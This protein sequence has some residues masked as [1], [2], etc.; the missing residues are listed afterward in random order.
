MN[1]ESQVTNLNLMWHTKTVSEFNKLNYDMILYP[2]NIIGTETYIVVGEDKRHIEGYVLSKLHKDDNANTV[3]FLR[4]EDVK[5]LPVAIKN[6]RK[7][8][9]KG[10][11]YNLLTEG[12]SIK[13]NPEQKMV[14]RELIDKSGIP[15]HTN[16]LHWTLYKNK[17]LYSRLK[18]QVY[19]RL[20][21]ESAFGKDK[22]HEAVR[23]LLN[24]M[25]NIKDP[26]TPKLFYAICHNKDVRINEL[27]NKG[28]DFVK[29]CNTLMS[30]G[31]GTTILDNSS[32]K[33]EGTKETAHI[34]NLSVSFTHNIPAYYHSKGLKCFEELY[35]YNVINRYF[36]TH[37][38]GFL[39]AVFPDHI[40][41]SELA[42]DNDLFYKDWIKSCLW[43]EANWHTLKNRYPN[44]NLARYKFSDREERFKDHFVDFAR[45]L[46][47]YAKDEQEYVELLDEEYRC[48]AGGKVQMSDVR[49]QG[50]KPVLTEDKVEHAEPVEPSKGIPQSRNKHD[51]VST[52]DNLLKDMGDKVWGYE[53]LRK[54]S[55]MDSYHLDKWLDNNKTKGNIYEVMPG[56]FKVLK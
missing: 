49:V 8:H 23:L 38:T 14:W 18:G 3:Y 35:P 46:S 31:D 51:P 26:S 54:N 45:C 17:V 16:P 25:S 1:K 33:T 24:D 32:R 40:N 29:F 41:H 39:Q 10:N 7:V 13:I 28:A 21:T 2:S 37:Y 30:I 19:Y 34:E 55:G 56:N 42:R 48:H 12:K 20:V 27:P 43:Y 44:I 47:H 6:T 9:S 50:K 53:D 52:P 11:V 15:K 4:T 5:N 36:Y 22:Y